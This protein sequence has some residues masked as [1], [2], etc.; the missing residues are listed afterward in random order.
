MVSFLTDPNGNPMDGMKLLA[1]MI[2]MNMSHSL[3]GHQMHFRNCDLG[4][5]AYRSMNSVVYNKQ[6]R[7]STATSKNFSHSEVNHYAQRAVGMIVHMCFE[8]ASIV[9]FPVFFIFTIYSLIGL[10]RFNLLTAIFLMVFQMYFGH[11][12]HTRSH[13]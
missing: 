8:S 7:L 2:T 5:T 12:V 6:L 10:L 4:H 9:R 1:F 13:K 11:W 3:L